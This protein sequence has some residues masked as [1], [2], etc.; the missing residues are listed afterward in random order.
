[1]V[2]NAQRH[3]HMTTQFPG[4]SSG[5]LAST[6]AT[7]NSHHDTEFWARRP[8]R[9]PHETRFMT[10]NYGLI[11]HYAISHLRLQTVEQNMSEQENTS[12]P[13][14]SAAV[15]FWATNPEFEEVRIEPLPLLPWSPDFKFIE[16][17][18][19]VLQKGLYRHL[20]RWLNF[21]II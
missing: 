10:P 6:Q 15:C 13:R 2:F 16:H 1:M 7:S 17:T 4:G 14:Q 18:W 5:Y 19:N 21:M 8:P 11:Y 9:K 20:L 3:A 12:P